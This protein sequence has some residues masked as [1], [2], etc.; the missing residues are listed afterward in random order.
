MKSDKEILAALV[1][2]GGKATCATWTPVFQPAQDWWYIG[3]IY[4]NCAEPLT[5]HDSADFACAAANARP[6][7][8]R[9]LERLEKLEAVAEAAGKYRDACEDFEHMCERAVEEGWGDDPTG[10]TH[11]S[12]AADRELRSLAALDAALEALD[13]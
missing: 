11:V 6:A 8:K 3:R 1:E 10:S 7:L 5:D 9:M 12:S 4:K 13:A 2:A